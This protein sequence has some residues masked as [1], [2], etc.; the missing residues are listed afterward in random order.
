M[1]SR[2]LQDLSMSVPPETL[3]DLYDNAPVGYLTALDDGTTVRVNQTLL[4]MLDRP[5]ATILGE[6]WREALLTLA[7]R[8]LFETHVRPLLALSGRAREIAVDLRCAGTRYLPVL[9]YLE[10]R[11]GSDA[12]PSHLRITMVETSDRREF[13]RNLLHAKRESEEANE[14]LRELTA[15]LEHRVE[16]RTLDLQMALDELETFSYAVSH[17]LRAPLRA[18]L[19]FADLLQEDFGERLGES[20]LQYL[21]KIR[22]SGVRMS[23]LIDGLL[24]LARGAQGEI[25]RESIDLSELSR[26]VLEQL[27][28]EQPDRKVRW[29]V[30]PGLRVQA[31][32]RLMDSVMRNLLGNAWKYCASNP[33]SEVRVYAEQVGKCRYVCV[34]DNGI[35]FSTQEAA[36]VFKPFLRLPG[37]KAFPGTGIGLSTVHRII[38][39]HRGHIEAIGQTGKGATFRFWIPS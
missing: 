21:E 25:R 16:E 9:M 30:E 28:V 10:R 27:T 1:T 26:Q 18:V 6:D 22:R 2:S 20:G 17:D 35:G 39:R 31:D 34:A 5:A 7:G 4:R 3:A 36:Q 11:S 24:Q 13:E 33:D 19:G 37:A 23:E 14:S 15:D 32:R 29:S 38:Q 12:A 8:T